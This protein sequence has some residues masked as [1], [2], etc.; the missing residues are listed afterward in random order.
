[1]G[2]VVIRY[3]FYFFKLITFSSLLQLVQLGYP[4]IVAA[5]FLETIAVLYF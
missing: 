4:A 2:F 1:M 5:D 3:L